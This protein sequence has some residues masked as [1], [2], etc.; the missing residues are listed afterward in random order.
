MKAYSW[1]CI[2][3]YCQ[4]MLLGNELIVFIIF[5]NYDKNGR[6]K[7]DARIVELCSTFVNKYHNVQLFIDMR[8]LYIAAALMS[9]NTLQSPPLCNNILFMYHPDKNYT[10]I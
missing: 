10:V 8:I 1:Q 7:E 6:K 4:E 5:L 2:N 3:I 9:F